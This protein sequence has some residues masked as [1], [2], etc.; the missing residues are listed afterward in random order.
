MR[1]HSRESTGAPTSYVIQQA[2]DKSFRLFI[3]DECEG[4]AFNTLFISMR[5]DEHAISCIL[6]R[7]L[8]CERV[9]SMYFDIFVDSRVQSTRYIDAR[10]SIRRRRGCTTYAHCTF[11]SL[12]HDLPSPSYFLILAIFLCLCR[13][14]LS[15]SLLLF[16]SRQY[17]LHIARD[18]IGICFTDAKRINENS[19]IHVK[20]GMTRTKCQT[21][22]DMACRV[23]ACA[24]LARVRDRV[25]ITLSLVTSTTTNIRRHMRHL[26]SPLG[27]PAKR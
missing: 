26:V 2:F 5:V 16:S 4:C 19:R 27:N 11:C 3:A 15:L 20:G 9:T 8:L 22:M 1:Q 13:F 6:L 25:R 10:S 21:G 18:Y 14:C 12:T 24:Q 7:V 17:D 23:V